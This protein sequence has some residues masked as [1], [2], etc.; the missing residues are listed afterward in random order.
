MIDL[1]GQKIL[2][3][4]ICFH[5]PD[6]PTLRQLGDDM[7]ALGICVRIRG[8]GDLKRESGEG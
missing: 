6:C 7:I 3:G 1:F 5:G 2:T 8:V 4:L